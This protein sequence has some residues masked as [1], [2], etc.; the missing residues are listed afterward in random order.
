[1]RIFALE[2]DNDIKGINQ[3]KQYIES[4]IAKLQRPD[5]IVLPELSLCSYM[6]SDAIW[7]YADDNS[8]MTS[9]W[10]MKIAEKYNM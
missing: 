3:R 9:D 4:L 6:G 5:L 7:K 1:M 2:L 10:A 8:Q